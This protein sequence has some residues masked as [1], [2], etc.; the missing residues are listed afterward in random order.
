MLSD[1]ITNHLASNVVE[2][3]IKVSLF[4]LKDPNIH[5]LD[6]FM[7]IFQDKVLTFFHL[8]DSRNLLLNARSCVSGE[9]FLKVYQSSIH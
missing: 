4:K 8:F 9:I 7:A 2:L 5:L 3:V 1:N 6:L